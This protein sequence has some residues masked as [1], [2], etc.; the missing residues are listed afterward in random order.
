M[1]SLI[2]LHL[3]IEPEGEEREGANLPIQEREDPKPAV[4]DERVIRILKRAAHR[5]GTEF[6]RSGTGIFS[7]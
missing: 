1:E 4:S 2:Q 3:E 7:K 5:A 6:R